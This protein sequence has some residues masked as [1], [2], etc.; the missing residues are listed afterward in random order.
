M[1]HNSSGKVEVWATHLAFAGM[2]GSRGH[3]F[4][5]FSPL[6]CLAGIEQPLSK[7]FCLARLPLCNRDHVFVGTPFTHL[8]THALNSFIGVSRFLDSLALNLR[9]I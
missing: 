8:S 9:C 7:A 5:F 2:G 6:L 3:V 1:S 4:F